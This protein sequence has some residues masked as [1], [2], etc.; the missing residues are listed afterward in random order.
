MLVIAGIEIYAFPKL[1]SPGYEGLLVIPGI[2]MLT[3]GYVMG[4]LLGRL[5]GYGRLEVVLARHRITFASLSTPPARDA[6]T[7]LKGVY[8]FS[9]LCT[10]VL[11]QWFA[12]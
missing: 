6:I 2:V 7:A 10:F 8:G 3:A 9:I 4:H 11:C 12:L 1:F 5:F